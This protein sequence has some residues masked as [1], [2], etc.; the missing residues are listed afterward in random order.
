MSASRCIGGGDSML[1]ISESSLGVALY[2]L[3]GVVMIGRLVR[4][5]TTGTKAIMN[6]ELSDGC[7]SW[8]DVMIT[9]ALVKNQ[10]TCLV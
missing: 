10:I 8:R 7:N 9:S 4:D 5:N 3:V 6:G 2:M 1:V